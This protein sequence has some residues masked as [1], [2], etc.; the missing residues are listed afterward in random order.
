MTPDISVVVLN[1]NGR[2]YL[3]ACLESLARQRNARFEVIVVDNGSSDGSVEMVRSEFMPRPGFSVQVIAN[4][5][6]RG[7][8][9]GTTRASRP[10]AGGWPSS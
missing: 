4:Q 6:N 9:G 1:W 7:F 8:C 5:V 10:R 2:E 3:R